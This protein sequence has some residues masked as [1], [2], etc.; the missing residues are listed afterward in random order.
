VVAGFRPDASGAILIRPTAPG[1]RQEP[2]VPVDVELA[3][4][5]EPHPRLAQTIEQAIRNKLM[6]TMRVTLVPYR[7]LPRS[8][9]KT[10]LVQR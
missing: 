1:T 10:P 5:M 4:G 7:S 8:D 6:V 2:P 3:A 9:Y